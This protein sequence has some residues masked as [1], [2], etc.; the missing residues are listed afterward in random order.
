MSRKQRSDKQYCSDTCAQ[1]RI[2]Y[3]KK[4]A[5]ST[6]GEG[7][8]RQPRR[9]GRRPLIP[10]EKHV[11]LRQQVQ[12]NPGASLEE[13][14]KVWRERQGVTVSMPTMSRAIRNLVREEECLVPG[15]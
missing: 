1:N 9:V 2:R 5:A 4:L 14:C 11:M 10:P 12:N 8:E 6:R 3:D 7:S 13:H 15:Y